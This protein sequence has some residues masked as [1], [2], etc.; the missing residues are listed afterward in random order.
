MVFFYT[1]DISRLWEMTR[2]LDWQ[3]L[4]FASWERTVIQ[5]GKCTGI[6][7]ETSYLPASTNRYSSDLVPCDLFL[8]PQT[9]VASSWMEIWLVGSDKRKCDE[10]TKLV[11]RQQLSNKYQWSDPVQTLHGHHLMIHL[12]IKKISDGFDN[13]DSFKRVSPGTY[14][15]Y[16]INFNV[17]IYGIWRFLKQNLKTK[18]IISMKIIRLNTIFFSAFGL[19]IYYEFIYLYLWNL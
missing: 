3:R 9:K 16:C 14:W 15:S 7:D 4:D 18:S 17:I 1:V 5:S 8:P 6:F 13:R 11:W 2:F 12:L 19:S 10:G